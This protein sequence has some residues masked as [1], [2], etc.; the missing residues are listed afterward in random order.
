LCP[1]ADLH[2]HLLADLAL[3]ANGHRLHDQF[4]PACFPRS[5]LAVAMLPEVSPLPV[6]ALESVLVKEAHVLGW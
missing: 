1:P 4:H 6:A 5:I 2:V 3:G